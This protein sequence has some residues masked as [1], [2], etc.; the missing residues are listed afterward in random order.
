MVAGFSSFVSAISVAG[1][2]VLSVSAKAVIPCVLSNIAAASNTA[3]TERLVSF[4]IKISP[5]INLL[6]VGQKD[7]LIHSNYSTMVLESKGFCEYKMKNLQLK[8]I[9]I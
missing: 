6:H 7:D 3:V 5:Y 2:S 1:R 9:K 4:F 8:K